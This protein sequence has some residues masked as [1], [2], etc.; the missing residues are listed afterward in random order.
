MINESLYADL[1]P[2]CSCPL[3]PE[4]RS[5]R[6]SGQQD[7]PA[8]TWL[9]RYRCAGCEA[10]RPQQFWDVLRALYES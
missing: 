8:R 1:C 7:Q 9:Y 4:F 10:A 6:P 3:R 2:L 5:T